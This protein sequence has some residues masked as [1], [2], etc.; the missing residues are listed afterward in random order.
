MNK[1]KDFTLKTC[2]GQ[3]VTLSHVLEENKV[4]LL[5]YRGTF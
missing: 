2:E 1:F 5:F 3:E 4:W